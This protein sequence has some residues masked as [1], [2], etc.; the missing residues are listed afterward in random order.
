M[1]DQNEFSNRANIVHLNGVRISPRKLRVLVDQIRGQGVHE[2]LTRLHFADRRAAG[3]LVK[4]VE[5]GVAN[6]RENLR[7]WNADDLMVARAFVDA[8]PT[9]KRFRPRA[10]GRATPIRKRTSRVTIELRP[11]DE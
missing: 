11:F 7:A 1:K 10:Q 4:L 5:S 8:G 9:L 3:V 6:V 2:A